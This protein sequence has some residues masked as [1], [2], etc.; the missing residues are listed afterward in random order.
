M[1]YLKIPNLYKDQTVLLFKELYALE[2]IHGTSAHVG[3]KDGKVHFFSG[4]VEYL[5]F[6]ALFDEAKLAETF[7][8]SG[9]T[10]VTVFGE[11]YGGKCQGMR[12]T[13]GDALR[14]TVF[15]VRIGDHGWLTVPQAESFCHTLGLEFVWYCLTDATREALDLIRDQPSVQATRILGVD[16]P[17]EGIV[18]RP[19]IE[20][21]CGHGRVIAKHKRPEFSERASKRDSNADP[22]K[23]EALAAA[24]AI[25]DEWVTEMRLGH[26][27]DKMTAALGRPPELQDT[28]QVIVAMQEDICAEAQGEIVKSKAAM[29]EIGSAAARLFKGRL[30]A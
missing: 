17:A 16:R 15:D 19:T 27:L 22:L 25:A 21:H 29:R 5:N 9:L 13:Y 1:G 11:A 10:E 3:W 12:D 30:M 28:K 4:G 20:L 26:V 6:K 14:F 18:L 8:A 7:A 24:K 23:E 2:K